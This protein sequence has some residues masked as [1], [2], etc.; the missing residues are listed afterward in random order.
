MT[1]DGDAKRLRDPVVKAF[2]V[3]GHM[4][5]CSDSAWS[6]R[7]L[8]AEL[9][10]PLSTVH[11]TLSSL[12]R[13][14]IVEQDPTTSTYVLGRQLHRLARIAVD[15]FPLTSL[16]GPYLEELARETGETTLLGVYDRE[17]RQMMFVSQIEG[18]HA[19]RYVVPLHALIPVHLGASGLGILSFLADDDRNAVLAGLEKGAVNLTRLRKEISATRQRGYAL[20]RGQRIPGAVA[21]AAPV[22]EGHG[23]AVG[24]IVVTIPEARFT[25]AMG[26]RFAKAVTRSARELTADLGGRPPEPATSEQRAAPGGSR[27]RRAGR[28]AAGRSSS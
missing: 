21:V 19:L 24:D 28:S 9:G 27:S 12:C 17:Q 6:A 23:V 1:G 18:S 8:A 11:R 4:V 2:S 22:F 3:L 13:A 16:A 15:A 14:G 20:S 10:L 5:E 7:G 25:E 26:A